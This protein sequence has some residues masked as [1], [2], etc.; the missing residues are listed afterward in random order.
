MIERKKYSDRN[1]LN[2]AV[3]VNFSRLSKSVGLLMKKQNS[4]FL[5]ARRYASAG[6]S[7]RNVS[8]R[9]SIRHAPVLCKNEES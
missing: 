8:V 9:L 6:D 4:T 7:D 2:L 5:P 3:L 1:D